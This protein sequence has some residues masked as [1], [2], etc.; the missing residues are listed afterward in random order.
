MTFLVAS[1]MQLILSQFGPIECCPGEPRLKVGTCQLSIVKYQEAAALDSSHFIMVFTENS[2]YLQWRVIGVSQFRTVSQSTTQ[3]GADTRQQSVPLN[4]RNN[5]I[6]TTAMVVFQHTDSA[7]SNNG[8]NISF[9]ITH[10]SAV[11]FIVRFLLILKFLF[12]FVC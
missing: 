2:K 10:S 5:I 1:Q 3:T 12:S 6:N 11:D 7:Q 8:Q 4:F 9:D